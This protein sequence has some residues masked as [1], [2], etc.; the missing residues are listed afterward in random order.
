MTVWQILLYVGAAVLALRSFVQ[1]V[2]NY[3][4]EYEQVAV[5]EE[6]KRLQEQARSSAPA[7]DDQSSPAPSLS[8][9]P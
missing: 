2:T 9:R 6:L 3:R 7:A 1:L 8:R 5:A 4:Q